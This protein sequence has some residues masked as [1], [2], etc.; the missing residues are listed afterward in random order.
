MNDGVIYW[1]GK[2]WGSSMVKEKLRDLFLMFEG[3]DIY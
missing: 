2:D 3:W 1:D